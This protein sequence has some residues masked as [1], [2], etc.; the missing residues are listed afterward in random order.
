MRTIEEQLNEILSEYETEAGKI[1]DDDL[2]KAANTARKT[3]R[4]NSPKRTGK[5]RQGWKYKRTENGFIVFN[6]SQ[7]WKTHLL[8]NGHL[9]ADGSK[10]V[11]AI[12]HIAPAAETGA[13]QLINDLKKDL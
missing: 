6:A 1:L 2:K 8:E 10:R 4:A 5:Y 9:T 13:K 11:K 12:K 7:P 3:V